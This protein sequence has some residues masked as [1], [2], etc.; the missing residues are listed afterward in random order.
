MTLA[1]QVEVERC[2]DEKKDCFDET[3]TKQ[4]NII[5]NKCLV[6]CNKTKCFFTNVSLSH[7]NDDFC[8][9][10]QRKSASLFPRKTAKLLARKFAKVRIMTCLLF[11]FECFTN[12][13]IAFSECELTTIME[14]QCH[15][16]PKTVCSKTT[17][18]VE[19]KVPKEVCSNQCVPRIVEKCTPSE[20]ETICENVVKTMSYN[21]PVKKC[22]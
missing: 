21:I 22:F 10:F 7:I 13:L 2:V 8:R 1:F 3:N 11:Y 14:K 5:F 6:S 20:P 12:K 18:T 9:L 16:E 17:K 4:E 15:D 19:K